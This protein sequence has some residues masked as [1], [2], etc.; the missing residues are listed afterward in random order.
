MLLSYKYSTN[1]S[2]RYGH[3]PSSP[4]GPPSASK[5]TVS[6]HISTLSHRC[7]QYVST[8]TQV[9]FVSSF[10]LQI[11]GDVSMSPQIC[12][13]Y[14]DSGF[15]KQNGIKSNKNIIR[16]YH[17]DKIRVFCSPT[18]NHTSEFTNGHSLSANMNHT[19]IIT[20]SPEL[21]ETATQGQYSH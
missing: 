11:L 14:G 3:A 2:I 9:Y 16:P 4:P 5:T 13:C 10:P 21:C 15:Q 20:P 7:N 12:P 6:I 17:D 18:R 8:M 1:S 19:S